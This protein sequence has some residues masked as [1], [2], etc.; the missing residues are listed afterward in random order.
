MNDITILPA[1]G[2]RR[3]RRVLAYLNEKQIPYTR[4]ELESEEGQ[5]LSKKHQL[6][7]SPGILV[8]GRLINP[9]DILIQPACRVAAEKAQA[10]FG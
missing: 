8:N 9:F 3:S 7:S 2:C 5:A 1:Q 4:I 6:R 10:L